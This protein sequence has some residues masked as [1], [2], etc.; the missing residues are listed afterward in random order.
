ME[1]TESILKAIP[2]YTWRN[3]YYTW[4]KDA[5]F[6]KYYLEK[7]EKIENNLIDKLNFHYH[8]KKIPHW[9]D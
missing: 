3:K 5:L 6:S 7:L 2:V 1:F 8:H 4:K 9:F